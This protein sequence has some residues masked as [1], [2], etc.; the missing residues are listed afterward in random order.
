MTDAGISF[1]IYPSGI[2]NIA[3]FVEQIYAWIWGDAAV[4]LNR[5]SFFLDIQDC[6]ELSSN[7]IDFNVHINGLGINTISFHSLGSSCTVTC[8]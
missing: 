6:S 1:Q 4:H 8:E 2:M 3:W 7:T 5:Q